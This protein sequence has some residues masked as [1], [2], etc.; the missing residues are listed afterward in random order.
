MV[1]FLI[2]TA[3]I[4]SLFIM[5]LIGDNNGYNRGIKIKESEIRIAVKLG[6][7]R[8]IKDSEKY[9]SDS[10]KKGMDLVEAELNKKGFTLRGDPKKPETEKDKKIAE[11]LDQ[12]RKKLEAVQSTPAIHKPKSPLKLV[13]NPPKLTVIK[14]EDK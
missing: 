14:N 2:T 7:D 3:F 11:A 4:L 12:Q 13:K 10:M 6:Y 1:T 5:F 9:V 8:G